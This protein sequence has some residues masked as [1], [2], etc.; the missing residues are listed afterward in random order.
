MGERLLVGDLAREIADGQVVVV[1]GAGVS[2]A[3]SGGAQAASWTGLLTTG[4]ERC[5]QLVPGLPAGWGERVRGEIGSGDL[6]D[7]LSAAEKVTRKLGGRRGGEYRR[8]LR[9]TV[10]ALELRHSAAPEALAGLGVPLV[11][12][13]YDGLLAGMTGLEAVTWRDGPRVQQVLRGEAHGIVH[14]HGHWREPESVVLG[15]RSYQDVLDDA[16]AQALLHALATFR[17]FLLV[18]F[19]AGLD[20]PNFAALRS[21]MAAAHGGSE[22]R[23]YRLVL[24]EEVEAVAA[25]HDQRERVVCVGYGARHE[26]L[27]G[28]LPGLGRVAPCAKPLKTGGSAGDEAAERRYREVALR[29]FDIIDL[30]NL[31][32]NDR[33]LA[34]RNLEL[35]RLYVALHVE[36]EVPAEAELGEAQLLALEE[37]RAGRVLGSVGLR[38]EGRQRVPVGQRLGAAARLVVLGDPG[39]GKTTLLR[40]LATAYL[41]R[42]QQDTDLA[43]L[44]DWETLPD[45]DWLPVLVRCRDLGPGEISGSVGDALGCSL[46]K[47]ELPPHDC[48]AVLAMLRRRLAAGTA[49]VLVDGLDEITDPTLRTR[50]CRQLEQF[51]VAHPQTP[52]VVTSRIVGYRELGTR[53]GRGFEHLTL[54]EL[55]REEKDEF[56][57]RWCAL[58]ELPDRRAEAEAGLIRDLHATQRIE[59]LTGNPML[60]TTMALVR[61][62]VGKLPSRRADLYRAAVEV[63]LSWRSEVDEPLD[64]AEALPQL[65]YLAYAMCDRG[66]QQLRED[67]AVGLLRDLREEY[68]QLRRVARRE[69][70]DFLRLLEARTGILTEAG[71]VRHDGE[72]VPVYEFRHLT[73]QEYLA[74]LA[75]VCGHFP[76]AGRSHSLVERVTAVA[77]RISVPE[78]RLRWRQAGASPYACASPPATTPTPIPRC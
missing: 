46:R 61:R 66:V 48:D 2:I 5:E 76:G 37:R 53:I 43:E 31:P 28:F 3:A 75:L 63:L 35:R 7:L 47:L 62:R 78:V 57:K 19:G 56:A 68:P 22:Y 10:G 1:V 9:E 38:R 17:S 15:I 6:D 18:G 4:V 51:H 24:D 13:N 32:E 12:T 21:W 42:L 11:T 65:R 74:G 45:Q 44:P 20:D 77:G 69:P 41:L 29:A 14:L 33:H 60:L 34:T 64:D 16:A 8:W 52:I 39:A 70:E 40:W 50:F 58:T 26:D 49:L 54:S 71:E 72:L 23:H 55:T 25:E 36:V 27:A 73:F 30:A 67:E 59:D